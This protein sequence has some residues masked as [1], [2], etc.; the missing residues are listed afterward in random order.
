MSHMEV[1]R[2]KVDGATKAAAE[3][4]LESL[5]FLP[6][7][8][9]R[10]FYQEIIARNAIPFPVGPP[11]GGLIV[12]KLRQGEVYPDV[13]ASRMPSVQAETW[14]P[15]GRGSE[16]LQL[17]IAFRQKRAARKT[18]KAGKRAEHRARSPK[19]PD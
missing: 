18:K 16:M 12:P 6:A 13:F 1:V 15:P 19:S 10:L 4:I 3:A 2:A 5:G 17:L 9:I 11:Q 8:A 7:E 14:G